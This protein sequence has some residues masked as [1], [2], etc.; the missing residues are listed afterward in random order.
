LKP[1]TEQISWK[2]YAVEAAAIV[3]NILLAFAIDAKWIS[4]TECPVVIMKQQD[5]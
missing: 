4:R 2:R 5:S 1:G 3:V